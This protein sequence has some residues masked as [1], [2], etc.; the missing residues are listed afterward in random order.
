MV[1]WSFLLCVCFVRLSMRERT[2]FRSNC[3]RYTWLRYIR[4]GA[5]GDELKSAKYPIFRCRRGQI[6]PITTRALWATNTKR[7]HARWY[8][9]WSTTYYVHVRCTSTSHTNGIK[10]RG[11]NKSPTTVDAMQTRSPD[12]TLCLPW[13]RHGRCGVDSP[14]HPCLHCVCPCSCPI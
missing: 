5:Y 12:L 14:S 10:W 3:L 4:N 9:R 2:Y 8:F 6:T 7:A 1:Y 13:C 11:A